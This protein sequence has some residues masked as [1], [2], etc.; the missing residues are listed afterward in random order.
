MSAPGSATTVL[1]LALLEDNN[2]KLSR[3]KDHKAGSIIRQVTEEQSKVS[4]HVQC[5]NSY[6]LAAASKQYCTLFQD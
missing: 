6:L 5:Y 3:V 2:T 1:P 4:G